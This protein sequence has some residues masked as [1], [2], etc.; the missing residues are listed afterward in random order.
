[1]S[2]SK[3][4]Y[5]Y[6]IDPDKKRYLNYYGSST[7]R[8][9]KSL[10][11]NYQQFNLATQID[12]SVSVQNHFR[13]LFVLRGGQLVNN[14]STNLPSIRSITQMK[15]S[16]SVDNL[17]PNNFLYDADLYIIQ[18]PNFYI[19]ASQHTYRDAEGNVIPA[20]PQL[21][22]DY[23]NSRLSVFCGYDL[24]EQRDPIG[25]NRENILDFYTTPTILEK[26]L[27]GKHCSIIKFTNGSYQTIYNYRLKKHYEPISLRNNDAL[28]FIVTARRAASS[29]EMAS[30]RLRVFAEV[31]YVNS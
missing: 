27:Y 15:L 17:E 26:Q 23:V 21:E 10:E 4:P 19:E 30:F 5:K 11:P 22:Y 6:H 24:L 9:L 31:E 8:L 16:M 3:K 20:T 25:T 18:A 28:F 13:H 29:F 1:M 12:L 2:K 7:F 14:P